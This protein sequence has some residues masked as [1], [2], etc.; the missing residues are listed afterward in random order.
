[1]LS[2]GEQLLPP[3]RPKGEARRGAALSGKTEKRAE[4]GGR[5]GRAREFSVS[6][7]TP[8][9]TM[10]KRAGHASR[11]VFAEIY[12]HL[13]ARPPSWQ[14]PKRSS[15]GAHRL[16]RHCR[17]GRAV[18]RVHHRGRRR[19]RQPCRKISNEPPW[20]RRAVGKGDEIETTG[21]DWPRHQDEDRQHRA[22]ADLQVP[23]ARRPTDLPDVAVGCSTSPSVSLH[24]HGFQVPCCLAFGRIRRTAA[25]LAYST[26]SLY[27]EGLSP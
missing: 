11:R 19:G 24:G 8:S 10:R 27:L 3:P 15:N 2:N 17:H 9:T 16:H 7:R 4:V 25:A 18:T 5:I 13:W 21:P 26:K 23:L 22:L 20:A 1:M 6:P 14:S 12:P